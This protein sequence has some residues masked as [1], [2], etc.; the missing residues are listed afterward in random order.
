[1]DSFITPSLK[2]RIT[3]MLYEGILLFGVI[4]VAALVFAVLMQQRHALQFRFTLEVVLFLV[5]GLYFSWCWTHGGQTLPMKTW[6]IKL[7]AK[8]GQPL[9]LGQ[10]MFRYV[11]AWMWLLPGLAAA[12]LLDAKGWLSIALVFANILLWALASYLDP[13]R[14]FLHDRI[15][16]TR[17]VKADALASV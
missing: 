8:G 3:S 9:G 1:M 15:A 4:F 16:G 13:N 6:R 5:I 12:W 17:L 10:A 7:V 11:L 2:R 14:Q